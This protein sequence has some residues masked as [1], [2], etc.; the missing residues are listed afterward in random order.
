[1]KLKPL[2]EPPALLPDGGGP[3]GVVDGLAK[4][5]PPPG[6]LVAGVEVVAFAKGPLPPVLETPPKRLEG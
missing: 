5:K 3:A 6:L 4:E 1:M 2:V